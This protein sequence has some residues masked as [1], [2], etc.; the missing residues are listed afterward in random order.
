MQ[1]PTYIFRWRRRFFWRSLVAITHRYDQH[2]DKLVVFLDGGAGMHEI[3]NWSSCE[4]RLGNDWVE[5]LKQ[6]KITAPVP[7]M[8][9]PVRAVPQ[10]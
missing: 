7:Q 4:S 9:Q 8:P 1:P 10:G 5:A 6:Q 3:K 2:Q